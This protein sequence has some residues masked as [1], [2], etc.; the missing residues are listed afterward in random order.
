MSD[1]RGR[2]LAWGTMTAA[3]SR[4]LLDDPRPAVQSRA[5]QR[6]QAGRGRR[7]RARPTSLKTSRSAEAAAKRGLGVDAHPGG[8]GARGGSMRHWRSRRERASGG[9]SFGRT[10]ARRGGSAAA[11]RR[12]QIDRRPS[13]RAAAEALGRVGDPRAVPDLLRV[14]ASPLDRVLEHSLTYALIEIGDPTSTATGLQASS[15]RAK[16]AALIALDQMDGGGL[17]PRSRHPAA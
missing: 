7:V 15:S 2:T 1:P 5:L 14:A 16:R 8:A 4:R 13:Q 10:L 9:A 17:K 11:R 3:S 12:A 6:S